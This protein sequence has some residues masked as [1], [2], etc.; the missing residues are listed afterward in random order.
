MAS[1]TSGIQSIERAFSVLLAVATESAGITDIARRVQSPGQHRRTVAGH[2]RTPRCSRSPRRRGQLPHWLHDQQSGSGQ[3][4]DP[5]RTGS[6]IFGRTGR[7]TRRDQ[8]TC[9]ARR[10]RGAVSR[11][12]RHG[13]RHPDSGLDR[14]AAA[15]ARGFI[16]AGAPCVQPSRRIGR[17]SLRGL[18][19]FTKHTTVDAQ[20]TE[21]RLDEIRRVGYVWTAEEFQIGIT[22]VAAPV[23]NRAGEVV[24]RNPLPRTELSLPCRSRPSRDRQC[25]YRRGSTPQQHQN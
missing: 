12:R 24:A 9:R 14:Q 25:G 17:P 11:S 19:P 20:R 6:T 4:H 16:W 23:R 10:R 22:S 7:T 2:P 5:C 8:R 13:S 1:A 15:A 3:R 21:Q 18:E